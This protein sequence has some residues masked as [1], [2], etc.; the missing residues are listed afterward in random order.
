MSESSRKWSWLLPS[1][2]LALAAVCAYFAAKSLSASSATATKKKNK[3]GKKNKTKTVAVAEENKEDAV[4][5]AVENVQQLAQNV[6]IKL[7]EKLDTVDMADFE[8][9]AFFASKELAQI[10]ADIVQAAK[11]PEALSPNTRFDAAY[12]SLL[13]ISRLLSVL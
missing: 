4:V 3:K 13:K 6:E 11:E 9:P 8:N 12:V 2:L 5:Q 7:R 1:G 10:I